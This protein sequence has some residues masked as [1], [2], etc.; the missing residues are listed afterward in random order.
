MSNKENERFAE[1]VA[2]L[3]CFVVEQWQDVLLLQHRSDWRR[4]PVWLVSISNKENERFVERVEILHCFV[5]EQW[6]G[7]VH[8]QHRSDSGQDAVC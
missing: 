7:V 2:M 8:L 1:K 4:G 6:Q 5:V 3:P